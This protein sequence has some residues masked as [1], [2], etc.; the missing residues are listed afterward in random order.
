M[1]FLNTY[2]EE[3]LPEGTVLDTLNVELEEAV[4]SEDY[5]RAKELKELMETL[6]AD[7]EE[8]KK[9]Y[10]L[11]EYWFQDILQE[12][13]KTSN[14]TL[15][16]KQFFEYMNLSNKILKHMYPNSYRSV[17]T[18]AGTINLLTALPTEKQQGRDYSVLNKVNTNIKLLNTIVSKF[19]LKTF[20]ELV[21]FIRSQREELFR[22]TGR[23]FSMV[24]DTIR[25]TELVGEKSEERVCQYLKELTKKKYDIDIDPVREV[26][27][28]YKDMVLGIDISFTV[29]KRE[30]TVQ[31]KPL[32][33]F[34]EKDGIVSVISSGR[35]KKYKTDYM[36]FV[37]SSQIILFR[38]DEKTTVSGTIFRIPKENLVA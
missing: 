29:N 2:N 34:K 20:D 30:C 10:N 21:K 16:Q 28:S 24:F 23:Y 36:A 33:G 14:F 22:E 37:S 25:S 5:E 6:I 27:S 17:K 8:Y 18:E 26:T 32:R 3:S 9:K 7:N 4:A 19:A 1:K 15:T 31:V 12:D 13:V 11:G 38:N 35:V